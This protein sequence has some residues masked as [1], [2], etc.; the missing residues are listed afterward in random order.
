MGRGAA[1]GAGEGE[2][3]G[4]K[5]TEKY[6]SDDARGTLMKHASFRFLSVKYFILFLSFYVLSRVSV[7]PPISAVCV[8]LP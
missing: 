2:G 6:A 3:R 4:G 1:A 7:P 8:V 5:W